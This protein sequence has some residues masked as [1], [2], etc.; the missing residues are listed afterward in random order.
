MFY[1]LCFLLVCLLIHG[2]VHQ[3][4]LHEIVESKW[5]KIS[6]VCNFIIKMMIINSI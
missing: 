5:K 2:S 6:L 3:E 1:I 4:V